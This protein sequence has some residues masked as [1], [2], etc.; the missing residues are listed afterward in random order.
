[1][2]CNIY[3]SERSRKGK[4][5]HIQRGKIKT[6]FKEKNMVT[7]GTSDRRFVYIRLFDDARIKTLF[8]PN[9]LQNDEHR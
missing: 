9:Q 3:K 4:R 1:M 7:I 8:S 2:L 5:E 6:Q